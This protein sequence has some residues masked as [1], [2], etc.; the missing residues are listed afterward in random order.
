MRTLGDSR[1]KAALLSAVVLMALVVAGCGGGGGTGGGT[2]GTTGGSDAKPQPGGTLRVAAAIEAINLNP[3]EAVET[4]SEQVFMQILEPLFQMSPEGKVEP[5][6][7]TGA[8]AADNFKQWTIDLR[9]GIKFSDGKPMTAEDVAFSLEKISKSAA[10]GALFEAVSKVKATSPTTVE[11]QMSKPFSDF[12]GILALPFAA[13]V[14][15]NYG[16]VSGK[17]FSEHPVGTGPFELAAWKHGQT[18]TLT[19]NPGYWKQGLPYLE[20]V[21]LTAP[22]SD[23]ARVLQLKGE[24]VDVIA[25]VPTAQVAPLESTPGT[26]VQKSPYSIVN[27]FLPNVATPLFGNP[28]VREA[29]DL[30]LDR[31]S[32][33]KAAQNGTG[34][35]GGSWLPKAVDHWDASLKA[36]TQ[37]TAKAKSLMAEA[38]QEGVDP[39]FTLLIAAGD[40]TATLGAQIIQ[41][42]LEEVGFKVQIKPIDVSTKIEAESTG[43]F[44]AAIEGVATDVVDSAEL[45]GYYIGSK[46]FFAQADTAEMQK[47]LNKARVVGDEGQ[48]RKLYDEMQQ[49]VAD[50]RELIVLD[51]SPA[52][53]G[54]RENVVGFRLNPVGLPV[55]AEAGFSE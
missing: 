34:E 33:N 53:W 23:E 29:V 3:F 45:V 21:V 31:E 42:N 18:I 9:P 39:S 40:A 52:I 17:E 4:A 35:L 5:W 20:K 11:V 36:P 51:Y 14:P 27:Y 2:S 55:Y 24:Q 46:A 47:L 10:W 15:K 49:Y 38:V 50:E 37:D 54:E 6:L 28:K 8:K 30:A 43:N 13:I 48:L 12:E 1:G 22:A 26:R 19:K 25:N 16:G 41:E 32:Y 7:A 44:D